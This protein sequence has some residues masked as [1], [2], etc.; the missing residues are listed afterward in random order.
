MEMENE[1]TNG[2]AI[3][4]LVPGILA[5]FFSFLGFIGIIIAIVGLILA[6]LGFQNIKKYKQKGRGIAI[7][8][9]ICNS[10]GIL[11]AIVLMIVGFL[12]LTNID[13]SEFNNL[14]LIYFW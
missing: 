8:G 11:L 9:I 12:V 13:S 2:K 14:G 6:I 3:A 10:I 1:V 5:I 7:A 4:G